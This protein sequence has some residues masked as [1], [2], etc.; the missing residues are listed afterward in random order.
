MDKGLKN[1]ILFSSILFIFL[2]AVFLIFGYV[3]FFT[4]SIRYGYIPAVIIISTVMA[5]MLV[6]TVLAVLHTCR[7][8]YVKGSSKW[9]VK[10]GLKVLLPFFMFVS[11]FFKKTD[12][13]HLLYIRIN[14]MLVQSGKHKCKPEEV[15]VLLPHC[16]Q[17]SECIYKVAGKIDN[18]HRCGRC[19]IGEI[20][21]ICERLKVKVEVVSGGTA[22]RNIVK[23]NCPEIIIAVACERELT[24]GILDVGSIPVIAV[25]N[26]RPYGPCSDT[27]V[28]TVYLEQIID[29]MLIK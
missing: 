3:Y 26:E 2:A 16:L 23:M 8:G 24:S 12:S 18:C 13:L 11:G 4:A 22:A 28:D 19:K 1:F 20:L 9:L 7:R 25:V 29:G 21:K 14:N 10:T 6:L 5:S 17:N 15:L 27:T